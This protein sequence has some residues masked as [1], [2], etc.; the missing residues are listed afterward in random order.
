MPEHFLLKNTIPLPEEALLRS[1]KLSA[2]SLYL[3]KSA[4]APGDDDNY[5]SAMD[6]TNAW[7]SSFLTKTYAAPG[8]DDDYP[9]AMNIRSGWNTSFGIAVKDSEE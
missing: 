3:T 9:S 1:T 5:H 7:N 4:A 6:V 2:D 8:D